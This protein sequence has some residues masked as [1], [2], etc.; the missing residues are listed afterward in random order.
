MKIRPLHPLISCICITANRPEKL[1]K[2]ILSFDQ[3][4]YP[5][6]ELVISYPKNDQST[7]DLITQTLKAADIRILEIERNEDES[8]GKARNNAINI[9]NGEYICIWD[10]DDIYHYS[11]VADQHN[12]MQ[13]EGRYFQSSIITQIILYDSMTHK[14]YQ[15]F[16]NY[17]TGSLMCKKQHILKY[18]C[19]DTNQFECAPVIDYLASRELILQNKLNPSLY[20]YVYHGSNVIDYTHFQY[21]LKRSTPL[22][23][24]SSNR[25]KVHLAQELKINS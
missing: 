3:Q 2:T 25:I 11:R 14:A 5:N 1:L 22:S 15:S 17:W 4:S 12:F 13:G 21:Y 20:I 19:Q 24:E 8:I 6:K 9:C 18:P 10:D 23:E 7:K 16:Q